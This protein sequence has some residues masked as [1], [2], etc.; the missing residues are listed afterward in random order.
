M[1]GGNVIQCVNTYKILGV[2]MDKDLKWNCHV[3]Y[4]TKKACKKF[5]SIRVLRRAGVSEANILKIY[6]STVR[7]VL[8]CAVPV[9]QAIPAYLCYAI[10]RVQKRALYIIYP[11]AE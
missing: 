1:I 6:L 11:E 10:E 9:W 3:E 5:Y 4:I 7:P 2:I 8:E